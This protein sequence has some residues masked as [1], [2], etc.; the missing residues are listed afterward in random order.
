MCE[1]CVYGG[2]CACEIVV[3]MMCGGGDG[4]CGEDGMCG[5]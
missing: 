2:I 1:C 4:V 5:G 3:M